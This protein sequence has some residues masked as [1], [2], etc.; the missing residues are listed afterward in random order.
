MLVRVPF[1]VPGLRQCGPLLPSDR[2]LPALMLAHVGPEAG[3]R[4]PDGFR[5]RPE[6]IFIVVLT[7]SIRRA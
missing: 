3:L 1:R 2:L 7:Y 4:A 5:C 6:R